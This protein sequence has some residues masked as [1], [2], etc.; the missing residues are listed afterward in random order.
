ME[1]LRRL[2]DEAR[3]GFRPFPAEKLQLLV[4]EFVGCDEK[5]LNL[6]ADWLGQVAGIAIRLLAM[7]LARNCEQ[8]KRSRSK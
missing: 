8:A 4:L 7:G 5:F 2:G 6:L 3:A 1:C